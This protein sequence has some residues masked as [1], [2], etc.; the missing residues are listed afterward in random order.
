MPDG[1]KRLVVDRRANRA[2][3]GDSGGALIALSL[4]GLEVVHRL[5]KGHERAISSLALS[6][7]GRLLATGGGDRRVVLRDALTFEAMLTFPPGPVPPATSPS[8]PPAAGSRSPGPTRTSMLWDL[9]M[10]HGEL[11]ALGLAWDEAA[12]P[13][14]SSTDLASVGERPRPQVP[15]IRPGTIDPAEVAKG[16]SLLNSGI[17]AFRKGSVAA[18]VVDL[19]KASEQFQAL[20]LSLPIDPGLARRRASASD[21][22]RSRCGIQSGRSR[23]WRAPGSAR[24]S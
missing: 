20:R 24:G 19:Q 23:P 5:A 10:V 9:A 11:A 18:A 16:Q 14:V 21:F 1:C 15:V 2:I 12:P 6:P 4:P 22:W 17:A 13:S 7:D 8:T 3:L